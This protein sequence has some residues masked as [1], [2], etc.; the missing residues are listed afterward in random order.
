MTNGAIPQL[1]LNG[2]GILAPEA[3][4]AL[5]E[6]GF[7]ESAGALDAAISEIGLPYPRDRDDRIRIVGPLYSKNRSSLEEALLDRLLELTDAFLDGLGESCRDFEPRMMV[8]AD[9][10]RAGA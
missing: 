9:R 6:I 10:Y 5:K 1:F 8:Y 7:E 4:V 2:S 3:V